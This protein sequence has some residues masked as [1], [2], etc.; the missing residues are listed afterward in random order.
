LTR[1]EISTSRLSDSEINPLSNIQCAVPEKRE[2][3][4]NNVG[5]AFLDW[6]D[7]R[8]IDFGATTAVYQPEPCYRAP[9]PVGPQDSPAEDAVSN[10]ARGQIANA[11]SSLFERKRDLLFA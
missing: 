8:C 1:R 10:D 6:S 3:V 4:A 5:A 9:L 2:T 7:M 11:F